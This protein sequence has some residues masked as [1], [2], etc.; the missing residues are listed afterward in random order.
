MKNIHE[1][2]HF[3]NYTLSLFPLVQFC[4][5]YF[6]LSL[7]FF[8]IDSHCL[9]L[10]IPCSIPFKSSYTIKQLNYQLIF[11]STPIQIIIMRT[12]SILFFFSS[13]FIIVVL[14]KYVPDRHPSINY[15]FQFA[16]KRNYSDLMNHCI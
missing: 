7:S 12:L 9:L 6:V 15:S 5:F 8:F 2:K 13:I 1:K 11:L 3:S 4:T 14:M 10:F 16:M